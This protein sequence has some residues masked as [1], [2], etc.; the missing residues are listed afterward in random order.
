MQAAVGDRLRITGH[1][2]GEPDRCGEVTEV[3][4]PDG[5]PP[6]MIRWD[7]TDHAVLF[8]PGSD[9]RVEHLGPTAS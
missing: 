4:G 6:W 2:V 5:T 7:D 9:A 8:F 3:R 1:H